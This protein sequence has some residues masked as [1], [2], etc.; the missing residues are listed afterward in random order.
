MLL[1]AMLPDDSKTKNHSN[2][3]L[4]QDLGLVTAMLWGTTFEEAVHP[5][6]ASRHKALQ[7]L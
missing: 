6:L 7:L 2:A 1:R 5:Q 4:D 3:I